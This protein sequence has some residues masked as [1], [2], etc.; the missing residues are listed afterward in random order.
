MAIALPTFCP[1]RP[2]RRRLC[3]A[4][5]ASAP[6]ACW[7]AWAATLVP[8]A[9]LP[10]LMLEDQHGKPVRV[11]ASTRR[12]VYTAERSVG[13]MV[14]K[15]LA[16]Q[17]V[18]VLERLNAVYVAD[19]SAMPAFITRMFA[20]PKMRELPF[21]IA[22]VRDG[23]EQAQVSDLPR[24]PGAATVLQLVDGRVSEILLPHNETQLRLALGLPP[25]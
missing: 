25:A 14:S 10:P 15:L 16:A 19:I 3:L 6:L 4:W 20:L 1:S 2:L 18:G 9:L 24:Q 8:G 17:P 22:L 5:L 23:A 13:D 21:A 12:L 11:D 7:T